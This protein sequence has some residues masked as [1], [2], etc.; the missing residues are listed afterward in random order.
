MM[1]VIY[2]VVYLLICTLNVASFVGHGNGM[3]HPTVTSRERFS[4]LCSFEQGAYD[5]SDS[6]NLVLLGDLH[7]EDDMTDHEVARSDCIEALEKL[8]VLS[9]GSELT[10]NDVLHQ[11]EDM[12]ARDLNVEQLELMLE[13]KKAQNKQSILM[14][15]LISLGDLGRKDIRHEP[16]DAGTSKSFEMAKD[17]LEGFK[18]PFDLVTGNHDLEGLDEFETDEENLNAFMNIFEKST[19]QFM[20]KVGERTLFVGLSTTRF[21]DAP[22]SSHEVHIS[23]EQIDWFL[24]VLQQHPHEKGWKIYVFSHAPICGSGLRVLQSVH[25]KNGCAWLNHSSESSRG[26]F[27]QAVRNYPQIKFWAS[28]HF[29]LSH[30]Y[31]D[32]ISKVGSCTFVQAGVVGKVS[33][34]DGRRQT[35]IVQ[36]CKDAIKIYTINHHIRNDDGTAEIRLDASVDL[37]SDEITFAHD[38]EDYDR[39]NWF[40]AYTPEKEDGCYLE[41]PD[42]QVACSQT[43]QKSVCWWHMRCG[44]VLGLHEG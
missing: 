26:T 6:F 31:E 4:R 43:V 8:S 24:N 41:L 7:M 29:H 12:P 3:M 34:R 28:G 25:V 36:G 44:A 10:V 16:G 42:G 39:T 9:S 38:N 5:F 30:D 33:T 13:R 23:K 14:S 1:F 40:R 35:R 11:I 18:L 21:R 37:Y 17:F 15:N 27:I 22:F 2:L 32:A 20:K 19:P